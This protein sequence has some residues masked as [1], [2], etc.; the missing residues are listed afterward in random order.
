MTTSSTHGPLR[1]RMAEH[2]GRN[3]LDGG[4]WPYS[5]DLATE[6]ADL[7]DHLPPGSSRVVRALFS[8]PDWDPAPRRVPIGRGYLKAGSFPGDDT[9][10][11]LLTTADRTVLRL[12]VVPPGFT[13]AQAE[14]ALLASAT[15]GNAHSAA[16]LLHEVLDHGEVDPFDLWAD[17]GGPRSSVEEQRP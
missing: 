5:R 7:V 16:E 8:P 10:L 13:P 4:W 11:M 12:L 2:A 6:L 15:S 1:L 14:E 9:H 17:D 3:R